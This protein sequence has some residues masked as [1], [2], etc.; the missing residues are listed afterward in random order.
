MLR[1][2]QL[3]FRSHRHAMMDSMMADYG[4]R[5]RHLDWMLEPLFVGSH[6]VLSMAFERRL[7]GSAWKIFAGI[8][9]DTGGSFSAWLQSHQN[10]ILD[11]AGC[12]N[13]M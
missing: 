6:L 4:R 8:I 12:H 2:D 11:A 1:A 3:I 9:E 7:V 10:R 13:I 5:M